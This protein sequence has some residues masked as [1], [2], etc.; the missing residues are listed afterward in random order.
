VD[1]LNQEKEPVLSNKHANLNDL[2]RLVSER[3]TLNI[4]LKTEEDIEAAAKFLNDTIQWAGLNAT[5]EHKGTLE[6]YDGPIIIKQ[7]IE[8]KGRFRREWQL[9]R[10]P[11]SKRLLNTATQ[12][13][14]EHLHGNK[15]DCI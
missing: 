8:G 11:T 7:N 13:L 2:R 1:V 5:P 10:T 3:L 14:K 4:P 15:N 12:D 9:L 6:A